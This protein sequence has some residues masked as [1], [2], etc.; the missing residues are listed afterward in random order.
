MSA[1]GIHNTVYYKWLKEFTEA[2]KR[3][4]RGDHQR[5]ANRG[6]VQW[7]REENGRLKQLVAEY[8]LDAMALARSL[9]ADR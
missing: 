3:R 6:E 9:L 2:G 4:L 8:A 7:L 1:G 5:E